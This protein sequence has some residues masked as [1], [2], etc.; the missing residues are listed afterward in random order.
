M[1]RRDDL[2]ENQDLLD[3]EGADGELLEEEEEEETAGSTADLSGAPSWLISAGFHT[4]LLLAL[5]LLAAQSLQKPQPEAMMANI[6]DRKAPPAP[7]PVA[8]E[9][10]LDVQFQSDEKPVE[11]PVQVMDKSV[12]FADHMETQ[13]EVVNMQALARGEQ[14]AI[15]NVPLGGAG[16]FDTMG[17]GG[18]G[19]G[20][21]GS[22]NGGG[23]R[24]LV[25]RGGGSAGGQSAVERALRWLFKHQEPDG[26]WDCGK[27]GGGGN[28]RD[29]LNGGF[30]EAVTGLAVLAFLG[31]GYTEDSPKYG[32][33]VKK[34]VYWLEQQQQGDGS[35]KGSNYT[36]NICA[37]AAAE[38]YGMS[39]KHK[40]MAQKAIN[41]MASQQTGKGGWDYNKPGSRSD[42]SITGWGVMA[43]KSA[44]LSELN[45]PQSIF[46]GAMKHFTAAGAGESS[47][48]GNVFYSIGAAGGKEKSPN[49]GSGDA[50]TVIATL[51]MLYL[52]QAPDHPWVLNAA[53]QTVKK[54]IL[55]NNFYYIYSGALAMF[56]VGGPNWDAWNNG[57]K[58]ALVGSQVKDGSDN[59]G[60]WA[61][62]P[63]RYGAEGGRVYTT[64]LGAMS[65]EVYYRYLPIYG[66]AKK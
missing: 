14:D 53:E 33:T 57:M 4:V 51:A 12:E 61:P 60:S 36:H 54:G 30:D 20:R 22:R 27:Y 62:E 10:N 32:P 58:Q 35:W 65:L 42:T 23:R 44:K 49:P 13:D 1:P 39:G 2:D 19:G 34:A 56:Q 8:E 7:V 21:F 43:A 15:S 25:Q 3:G 11:H 29:Q 17:V 46:D 37:L 50:Q 24:N 64:A 52:G 16:V 38:A 41:H 28:K 6:E 63:D 55:Q 40:E 59:D 26:R 31:A 47:K 48:Q 66:G 9:T 5:S 18:G 45:V